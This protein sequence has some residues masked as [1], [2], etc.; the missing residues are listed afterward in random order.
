MTKTV[1]LKQ[2]EVEEYF[3][4]YRRGI[5]EQGPDKYAPPK[6]EN[7]STTFYQGYFDGWVG[8]NCTIYISKDR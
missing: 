7:G 8:E 5:K 6:P 4:G 2:S 1:Y 3:D